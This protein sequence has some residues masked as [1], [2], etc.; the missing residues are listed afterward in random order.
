[1]TAPKGAG[2]GVV[3]GRSPS[4][5]ALL[6]IAQSVAG[7]LERAGLTDCDDPGEAIDVI[8]ERLEK[9]VSELEAAALRVTAAFRANGR[10]NGVVESARSHQECEASLVALDALLP[11]AIA[12]AG[13]ES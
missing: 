9:R 2:G 11:P 7:A 3:E 1:M 8:R 6:L 5:D 10:A 12:K 4:Y 13:G